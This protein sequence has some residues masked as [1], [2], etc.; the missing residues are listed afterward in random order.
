M[1]ENTFFYD[2]QIRRYL[3]QFI[4]IFAD[5]SISE[6]RGGAVVTERV[7]IM[8]G[9]PSRMVA[10]ILRGGSDNTIMPSPM[11]SV[12]IQNI[13]MAPERRQDP[14]WV[15][16]INATERNGTEIGNRYS[17][18]RHMPVPY[19]LTLQLDIWTTNTTTK[20]QIVEQIATWFNDRIELQQNTNIYDWTALF[21]V[22]MT[23]IN[24]SG[25]SIPGG[26]ETERDVASL[27]FQL[28]IWINP[29][30][31]VKTRRWIEQI[32]TNVKDAGGQDLSEIDRRLLDPLGCFS[33]LAQVVVTPENLRLDVNDQGGTVTAEIIGGEIS[34]QDLF[35]LHGLEIN[36]T[37]IHL[38]TDDNIE[39]ENGDIVGEIS[40]LLSDKIATLNLDQDTI[41]T[42]D[43]RLSPII[44]IINPQKK[45]PGSGLKEAEIG[46]RYLIV[47]DNDSI[48]DP[49]YEGRDTTG[50]WGVLTVFAGDII[51]WNGVKWEVIWFANSDSNIGKEKYITNM[52]SGQKYKF[53]EG[54]WR[55]LYYGIFNPGYWRI[56][57]T[58]C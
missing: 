21:E 51:E 5:L 41:P 20:M 2:G 8:Y 48:N 29:P 24:W 19:N 36:N 54:E 52:S 6:N 47:S 13:A 58:K 23:D 55:H 39:S 30:A 45:A 25:R 50:P 37:N 16:K 35:D 33:E 3:V 40:T 34:W 4:R 26:G 46:D 38:K 1:S 32:V 17:I 31:K 53:N 10:N 42:D 15:G 14:Q 27:T 12:W 9:D 44:A 56:V 18:E 43:A 49:A 28:P 7:P 11:M 57:G 22:I